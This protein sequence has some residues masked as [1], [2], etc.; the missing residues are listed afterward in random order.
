MA[1]PTKWTSPE[2]AILAA[3]AGMV[4]HE[5]NQR[6][7]EAGYQPRSSSEIRYRRNY[8]KHHSPEGSDFATLGARLERLKVERDMLTARLAAVEEEVAMTKEELLKHL[9]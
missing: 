1:A 8:I 6:L 2:D 4:T 9:A 3:T 5:V 7:T